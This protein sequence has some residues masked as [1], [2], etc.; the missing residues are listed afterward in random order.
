[1]E[2]GTWQ[3]QATEISEQFAEKDKKKHQLKNR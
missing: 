1:L 3:V 2:K